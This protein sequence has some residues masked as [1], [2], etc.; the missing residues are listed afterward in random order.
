M[1][2]PGTLILKLGS[3][4]L[5]LNDPDDTGF[6]ISSVDL[7]N[8]TVRAVTDDLPGQDGS[9]DQTAYF[10][11]RIVKLQGALVPTLAG[12][13]R[14]KVFDALAPYISPGARPILVYSTDADTA[15]RCLDLRV[16]Q[17][18]NPIDHPLNASALSVQWVGQ[19][20][21][22]DAE[23]NEVDVPFA[24]G[25]TAGFSFPLTFPLTFPGGSFTGGNAFVITNGTYPT[26]PTLRIFGPCTDPAVYWLD[27]TLATDLGIQVV[28]S[29]LTIADGDYIEVDTQARTACLNGDSM[30]SRYNFVDFANTSWSPLQPGQNLLRYAPASASTDSE[31]QVLWRDSFL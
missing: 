8:P 18:T 2:L 3:L 28:F 12:A 14:A 7:G 27:P 24:T 10:S 31:C 13:S 5:D 16:D 20:I 17:W 25:S 19:P 29:G 23:I 6:V 4:S 15:E 1:T 9:F 26:W 11:T 21:A 30:A 22:Y